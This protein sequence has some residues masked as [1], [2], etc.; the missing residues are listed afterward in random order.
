MKRSAI[1]TTVVMVI[2]AGVPALHAQSGSPLGNILSQLGTLIA[3]VDALATTVNAPLSTIVA[4]L[5]TLIAKVDALETTVNALVP[6]PKTTTT[7]LFP[8]ASSQ[9]GFDTG[10]SIANTGE[11]SGS[12][13]I[14]FM[15]PQAPPTVVVA[16]AAGATY[17]STL[18]FL[19]PNF[20]GFLRANCD[21]P[22]A[23]GYGFLSDVG[24]Q[25]LAASIPVEVVP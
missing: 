12:C 16:I 23:R 17:V 19:A 13:T 2:I 18:Q 7:L 15:S 20:T 21:F 10:I 22:M 14:H 8:F 3:K 11:I 25:R 5:G 9:F 24:A 4:Q 1:V 6:Q